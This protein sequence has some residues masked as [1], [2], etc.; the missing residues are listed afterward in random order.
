MAVRDWFFNNLFSKQKFDEDKGKTNAIATNRD[1]GAVEI[2]DSFQQYAL[3]L[4]WTY[5]GQSDLIMTYREVSN[6]PAVDYAIDDIVNEAVSFTDAENA[7]ELDLSKVEDSELSKNIKD[8]VYDS[9]HKI[10]KQLD[11]DNT[12]HNRLKQF[13]IDGRVGYQK[14]IDQNDV[15]S[16][17]K[18]IIELDTRFLT[19]IRNVKYDDQR[20]VISGVEEYF[21]YDENYISTKSK[22]DTD[23]KNKVDT[24][25]VLDPNSITYVTSGL[26]DQKTGFAISWLHKAVRPAN[27][28]RMMENALLIY[29]IVRAPERRLFYVDTSNMT[30]TKAKQHIENLK[31]S[32]RNKMS[33]DPEKGQ[34]KDERHLMTMQEDYWLPRNSAGKGTEVGTIPGGDNLDQIADVLY[35]Q[36]ELYKALNVPLSRLEPEASINFGRQSEISRDELKFSKLISRI[37]KR[38]NMILLDLLKTD[39]ILSKVITAKE[40]N[41]VYQKFIFKYSQ[42]MYLEEMRKSEL[43]RERLDLANQFKDY[44]GKYVSH[45]YI[46]TEILKQTEKDMD[47]EDKKIEKELKDPRFK[48]L[49]DESGIQ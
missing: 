19:K 35:F 3:N 42:D 25:M 29:R 34:F 26:I 30:P 31:N 12:I 23:K 47:E 48:P 45:E 40:W 21:I 49:E 33:F 7:I 39:L 10:Y 41:E 22:K 27:Q 13:Y 1:D 28:Q 8:K 37:R 43:T 17:L 11:L 20:K 2:S 14:V 5:T 15:K 32:Y 6:F 16:G 36:K 18:D 38:F 24:G 9:Y 4:N 44:I 46:R